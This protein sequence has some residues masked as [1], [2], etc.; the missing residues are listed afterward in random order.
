MNLVIIGASGFIGSAI[1][2]TALARGHQVRAIVRDTTRLEAL[3]QQYPQQLVQQ[4]L[5]VLQTADLADA[6]ADADAV[7]S[8]FSGHAAADISAAYQQGFES[9]LTAVKQTKRRL[10]LVGGAASLKLPDDS[11]LLHSPHFPEQYRASALGAYAALQQLQ[12]QTDVQWSYL[13]PAAE[14]FPGDSQGPV[15]L[16]GDYLVMDAAG[17]SRISTDDYA[18]VMLNEVEQP[19]HPQ[20]RFT[21]AY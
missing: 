3:A 8:A 18:A 19:L 6:I 13:S 5:N 4:S 11:L 15:R 16:G 2:Q 17:Q 14:I 10:L 12:A 9:I 20:Q 7:I 21:A 1:T